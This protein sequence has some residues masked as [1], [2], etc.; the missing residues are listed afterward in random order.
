MCV[1]LLL[2]LGL[3]CVVPSGRKEKVTAEMKR[4]ARKMVSDG[5]GQRARAHGSVAGVK[6]AR[7]SN[8]KASHFVV[9]TLY[10]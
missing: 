8:A 3:P 7:A 4:A 1:L 5:Q 2:L 10:K 6:L 9:S